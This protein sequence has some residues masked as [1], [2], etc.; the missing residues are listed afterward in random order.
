MPRRLTLAFLAAGLTAGLPAGIAGCSSGGG[1]PLASESAATIISNA[2][3]NTVNAQSFTISGGSSA[4]Y[5]VDLTIVR[6][7]GCTGTIVQGTTTS[8]VVWI[9]NTV[10]AHQPSM[11]ANTWMKGASTEANLQGLLNLCKPSTYLASLSASTDSN[12]TRSVGVQNG[13]PA[14]TLALPGT[15]NSKRGRSS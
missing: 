5:S 12:A 7:L 3:A 9:G 10:Y 14:L 1:D 8:K 15:G 11:P 6:N 2:T 13:Q 4:S